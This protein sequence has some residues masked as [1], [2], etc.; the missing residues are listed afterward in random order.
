MLWVPL[1]GMILIMQ[2]TSSIV[3]AA[4]K[5]DFNCDAALI[6]TQVFDNQRF[7][8][9]L[10]FLQLINQHNYEEVK[11]NA[12]ASAFMAYGLFEGSYDEFVARRSQYLSLT[13]M[14][15]TVD[16]ARTFV[17]THLSPES[18][19][20]YTVCM[21][22]KARALAGIHIWAKDVRP[23]RFTLIVYWRPGPGDRNARLNLKAEGGELENRYQA[24]WETEDMKSYFVKRGKG[25]DTSVRANIS[26]GGDAGGGYTD[27]VTITAHLIY[28]RSKEEWYGKQITT[29]APG[30]INLEYR[31]CEAHP[32]DWL[33][34][35]DSARYIPIDNHDSLTST[36]SGQ[37]YGWLIQPISGTKICLY[38]HARG[39][40]RNSQATIVGKVGAYLHR[41]RTE[42]PD[43]QLI[44]GPQNQG[45]HWETPKLEIK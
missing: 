25:K 2:A 8:G 43:Q 5:F 14:N 1:A 23:D 16:Q 38:H 31:H 41:I 34:D 35:H 15:L 44:G 32:T 39:V 30:Y 19:K 36:G 13:E 45:V 37:N 28:E 4:E 3:Q 27:S 40:D 10:A 29:T 6:Q 33:F 18:L 17:H 21:E 20:A 24:M 9:R 22:G 42:T 11:R 7:S 26:L 12:A